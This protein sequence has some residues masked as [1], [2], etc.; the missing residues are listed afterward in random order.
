MRSPRENGYIVSLNMMLR[1]K[2][3]KREEFGTLA[4][5]QVLV[6]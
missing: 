4:E 1:D 2:R 5:A 6:E 3:L